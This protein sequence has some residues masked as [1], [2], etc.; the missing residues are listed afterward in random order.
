MATFRVM[1]ELTQLFEIYVEAE[2]YNEALELAEEAHSTEWELFT[3]R[4]YE[5]D[6]KVIKSSVEEVGDE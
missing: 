6:W 2:N 4:R 3:D 1:A 5:D